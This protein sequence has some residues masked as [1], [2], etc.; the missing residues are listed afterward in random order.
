[1]SLVSRTIIFLYLIDQEA[2]RL[3][4]VSWLYSLIINDQFSLFCFILQVSAVFTV[5]INAWKIIKILRSK[6][7]HITRHWR[8]FRLCRVSIVRSERFSWLYVPK[9]GLPTAK[10]SDTQQYDKKATKLLY[11]I[12]LVSLVICVACR[13][14]SSFWCLFVAN[15][16]MLFYL[17]SD[18]SI[19]QVLVSTISQSKP[20]I[21]FKLLSFFAWFFVLVYF[22][23]SLVFCLVAGTAGLCRVLLQPCMLVASSWWLLSSSSIIRQALLFSL[24]ISSTFLCPSV[25]QS[26]NF[27][28]CLLQLK[29]VAHLPWQVFI[30]R[31]VNTFIGNNSCI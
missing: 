30:Y 16:S 2:S 27:L 24:S 25:L 7:I 13:N 5:V 29:T 15:S 28:L 21:Q 17:F 23:F 10:E 19:T 14:M 3:V 20:Q 11:M 12:L 8:L 9:L 4:L 6:I 22:L 1:M 18:L 26:F 31:A